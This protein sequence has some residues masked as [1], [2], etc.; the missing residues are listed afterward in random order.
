MP[1]LWT[2]LGDELVLQACSDVLEIRI[3]VNRY[4]GVNYQPCGC[5]H[6]IEITLGYVAYEGEGNMTGQ[7][8]GEHYYAFLNKV[9]IVSTA[10]QAALHSRSQWCL[11]TASIGS[12]VSQKTNIARA[13]KCKPVHV[14]H[15]VCENQKDVIIKL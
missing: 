11:H 7:L 4:D 1:Q 14:T 9:E 8:V 10:E 6:N 15:L 12:A 13:K 5:Q 3:N 2:H